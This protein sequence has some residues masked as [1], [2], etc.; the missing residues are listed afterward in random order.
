MK[1]SIQTK[2]ENLGERFE[3]ITVL[4]SQPEVQSNQNQFRSLSQEYAQLDPIVN[5][6]RQYQEN[7]ANLESAK[8]MAKDS[9]PELREMAKE[10]I[11]EATA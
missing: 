8:E 6:Y 1:P 9:D 5:C 4:L 7:E 10:E 11:N 3:E 2:L